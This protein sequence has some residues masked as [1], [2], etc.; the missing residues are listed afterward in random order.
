MDFAR[1]GNKYV[2]D[3]KPWTTRKTDMER[4]R[5]TLYLGILAIRFMTVLLTPF[6]PQKMKQLAPMVGLP[7]EYTWNEAMELP[8][9]G[10]VLAAPEILFQRIES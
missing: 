10:Q 1:E 7:E 8:Q 3:M 4:T 2:D 5:V 9:V 6:L